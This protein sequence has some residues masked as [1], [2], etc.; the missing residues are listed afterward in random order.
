MP[1]SASRHNIIATVPGSDERVVAN[2][3]SG[4]ADVIDVSEAAGIIAGTPVDPQAAAERGY[5]VEP[6]EE[7]HRFRAAY[8][9]FIDAR[10]QDEVQLFFA[11]TYACNFACSYCYQSEY[12]PSAVSDTESVIEAFFRYVDEHFRDRKKYVT[13]FGGEPLL[14]GPRQRAV[15]EALV[16]GAA[17]CGLEV[18]VVTNGYLLEE[19]LD[20][21][22]QAQVREIQVTLDGVGSVHDKRRP[23]HGGG[24]TFE[25]I[26]AGVD[27]AL[28]RDVPINLRMVVDR[29]N[30]SG[31][32]DLAR[33]ARERS[34]TTHPRFKTQVG[35]NYELH[36][37]QV[38]QDRLYSRLGLAEAF[39]ALA[40]E[41][42]EVLELH[43]PTFGLAKSL[44]ETGTLPEPVFDSCPGAKTEWAFDITGRIYA[45]TAT[46]G[47][48]GEALGTFYP[49]VR[50]DEAQVAEWQDRDVLA[51]P[52]CKDCQVALA[53]G[54]GCA[55]LAKNRSG[56]LQGPDCRPVK[57]LLGLGM[58]LYRSATRAE[59]VA[60]PGACR[61]GSS[62]PGT[63]AQAGPSPGPASDCCCASADE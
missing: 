44:A 28:A 39:A 13:I 34:W 33:F 21:L 55:A 22:S 49:E 7:A 38:E 19:Y 36:Y 31:L 46:V 54:G 4:S 41:H 42:P 5:L 48:P 47:K 25:K 27:A 45:C 29:E 8:L 60:Q 17:A 59:P 18:A 53:C 56:R 43:R 23:L 63:D 37:C 9:D 6:D 12:A 15:I 51:I 61:C 57:E 32:V 11:P 20:L 24:P 40:A 26:V 35:R 14:P 58:A 1:L 52:E 62:A 30:L 3:L 10:D 2:L 50:L 16:R